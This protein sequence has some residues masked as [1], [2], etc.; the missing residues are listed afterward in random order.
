MAASTKMSGSP[1]DL[2]S[3]MGPPSSPSQMCLGL[4]KNNTVDPSLV[5]VAQSGLLHCLRQA[6]DAQLLT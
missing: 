5:V 4:K 2:S 6:N 3:M 1:S